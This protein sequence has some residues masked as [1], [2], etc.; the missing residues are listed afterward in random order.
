[1]L[2]FLLEQE[3]DESFN[4]ANVYEKKERLDR[5]KKLL[6]EEEDPL[7]RSMGKTYSDRLAGRLDLLRS[8]DSFRVLEQSVLHALAT[9]GPQ[10]APGPSMRDARVTSKQ[11]GSLERREIVGSLIEYPSLLSEPDVQDALGMLEGASARTVATLT[12]CLSTKASDVPQMHADS[13][14]ISEKSL[15]TS[16]FLAQIPP[17]IQAFASERLAAPH[18]ATRDEAWRHLLENARKL[19]NVILERET[20]DISRETYRAAGDWEASLEHAR[21]AQDRV[22]EKLGVSPPSGDHLSQDT[23]DSHDP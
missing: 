23:Q 10:P 13:H 5:V 15:D 20:V 3:L 4:A 12:Q 16:S 11:A 2:E 8:A 9:A 1:M 7:V 6:S 19:R 21:D 17:A 18:H 22:R 14:E